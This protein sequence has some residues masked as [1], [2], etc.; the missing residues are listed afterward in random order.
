MI[1]IPLLAWAPSPAL[2]S[3]PGTVGWEQS[4]GFLHQDHWP[5]SSQF[6]FTVYDLARALFILLTQGTEVQ[7]K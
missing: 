4:G 5:F 1:I 2:R 6:I 3:Y 7:M